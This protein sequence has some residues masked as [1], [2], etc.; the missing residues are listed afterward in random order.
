MHAI[1]RAAGLLYLEPLDYTRLE[2]CFIFYKTY[3]TCDI[4]RRLCSCAKLFCMTP[5]NHKVI[6]L[7]GY[8]FPCVH[9]DVFIFR[10]SL[11]L[12]PRLFGDGLSH[13]GAAVLPQNG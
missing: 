7:G 13:D 2:I 5:C 1:W 10:L 11:L 3:G 12:V 8:H 4:N 9:T 6:R